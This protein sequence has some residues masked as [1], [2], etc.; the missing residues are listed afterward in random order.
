MKMPLLGFVVVTALCWTA[1]FTVMN[2][3]PTGM[4]VLHVILF[5]GWSF[6][7]LALLC[8]ATAPL[9]PPWAEY[10][11]L[12]AVGVFCELIQFLQLGGVP[13]DPEWRGFAASMVGVVLGRETFALKR[14]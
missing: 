8:A 14:R 6:A 13:H 1:Y 3:S 9:R 10:A 11:L 5:A 12:T 4:R 2:F 7:A